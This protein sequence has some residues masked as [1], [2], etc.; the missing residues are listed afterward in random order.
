MMKRL[1]RG[2]LSWAVVLAAVTLF[3]IAPATH[4]LFVSL[5]GS[6]PYLMGFAKFAVLAT[7]GELL[8]L[9]IS[10][11]A[12]RQPAGLPVK[13]LVWG[14]VGVAIT[15]MFSFFSAGVTA[16][17]EKNLLPAGSGALNAFL[18]AFYTSLFMN[19]TFGP[20]FM[21]AHRASDTYIDLR[22]QGVH[23]TAAELVAAINWPDFINFVVLKTIPFWWIPVHTLTFLLPGEYR[24][25]AAAYLSIAL[26]IILKY[27]QS[28]KA[29]AREKLESMVGIRN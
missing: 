24:V 7:M 2:D 9:R 10:S 1:R 23:P 4:Q 15:F 28:R 11:G 13:V 21:A 17:T 6:H 19:L 27:A 20:M 26:G 12:W 25:L 5:T 18:K 22:T 8:A 14:L 3:F 29:R 16:V